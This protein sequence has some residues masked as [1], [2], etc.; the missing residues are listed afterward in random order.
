MADDYSF[1]IVSKVD[2]QLVDDAVNAANREIEV[3]FDFKGSVSRFEFNKKESRVILTSDHQGKLKSVVEILK[4]RLAKRGIDLKSLDFET[5]E[6]ALGGT[7]RQVVKIT[8]GIS[9]EKAKSMVA[10]IKSAKLKVTPSI[11]ADQVRVTSRS[12][13]TLQ[14]AITILKQKDYGIPVQ[15]TN[16]R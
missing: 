13:D 12:K 6:T 3:R 2:L 14:E 10:D 4:S 16:F 9:S 5:V 1:D 7:V 8:Q 11:Q 15:F